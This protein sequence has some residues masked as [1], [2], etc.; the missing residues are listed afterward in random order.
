MTILLDHCVP[1]RYA[2]LLAAWGYKV[3]L[4][5]EYIAA[6]A[7]DSEVISLAQQRDAVLLTVDLD[8]ANILNYPP[9]GFGGIIVMRYRVEDE[10]RLDSTLKIALED[11]YRDDM[12]NTLV[13]VDATRY[14][15]RR[16]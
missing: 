11:L 7:P 16:Q 2:R 6:N 8:F 14:R 12:R 15:I 9:A 1:R 4:S 5:T 10:S 13:I 3:E